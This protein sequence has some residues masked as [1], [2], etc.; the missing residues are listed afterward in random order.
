MSAVA[1]EE[2]KTSLHHVIVDIKIKMAPLT[3]MVKFEKD[4]QLTVFDMMADPKGRIARTDIVRKTMSEMGEVARAIGE[5]VKQHKKSDPW[6]PEA[7]KQMDLLIE[8]T[9]EQV[10]GYCSAG[11]ARNYLR[12]DIKFAREAIANVEAVQTSA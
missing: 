5:A 3:D 7:L 6:F 1:V 9:K 4:N 11:I 12:Q 8:Y 10:D 2:K